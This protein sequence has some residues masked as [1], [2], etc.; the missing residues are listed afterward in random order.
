VKDVN[1]MVIGNWQLETWYFSPYP[2]EYSRCDVL[3]ICE[4]ALPSFTPCV[5]CIHR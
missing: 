5:P 4:Y 3:Y 1:R 2:K